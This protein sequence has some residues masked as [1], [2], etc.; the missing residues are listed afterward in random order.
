[1]ER[2]LNNRQVLLYYAWEEGECGIF[3]AFKALDPVAGRK[4]SVAEELYEE[5]DISENSYS[6]NCN[7]M[8][9]TLPDTLIERIKADGVAEYLAKQTNDQE[10][11]CPVCGAPLP[12]EAFRKHAIEYRGLEGIFT[13]WKCPCC[14]SVGKARYR[15]ANKDAGIPEFVEHRLVWNGRETVFP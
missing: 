5:L 14:D 12:K 6:H 2:N 1:M 15:Y 3:H 7:C 11:T 10:F 8:Y 9:I 4:D 13:P